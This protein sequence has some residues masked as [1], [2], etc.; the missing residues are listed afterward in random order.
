MPIP[1]RSDDAYVGYENWFG[2]VTSTFT[3]TDLSGDFDS[4]VSSLT[5]QPRIGL[6]RNR[7][8][9]WV[10]GMYLDTEEDH[11]GTIILPIPGIPPVPCSVELEGS[12]K[13]NTAVGIGHTFSTKAHISFEVGFGDR[14]H[15]LFNFTFRF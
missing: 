11:S 9:F 12:D 7:W 15:T 14:D 5:I 6:I 13:W 10:G 4:S 8:Q 2:A 3:D 1:L